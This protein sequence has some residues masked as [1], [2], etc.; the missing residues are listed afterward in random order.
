MLSFNCIV[1]NRGLLNLRKL[2]GGF[3]GIVDLV[4]CFING[5]SEVLRE[6]EDRDRLG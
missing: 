6:I 1:R 3:L 5:G 2:K 4:L